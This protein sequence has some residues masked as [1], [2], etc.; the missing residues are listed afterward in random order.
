[1]PLTR[2]QTD[3]INGLVRIGEID[4]ARA[5]LTK[6]GATEA[7][8]RLN[9]RH[10]QVSGQ[11][12]ADTR[13]GQNTKTPPKMRG[14]VILLSLLILILLMLVCLLWVSGAFNGYGCN[15]FC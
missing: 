12:P 10:P 9:A 13:P 7:L 1:M 15:N 3:T 5:L 4:E 11:L 2:E 6:W 14:S 8:A